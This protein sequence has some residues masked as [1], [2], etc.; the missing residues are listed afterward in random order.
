M[1]GS[2]RLVCLAFCP[3]VAACPEIQPADLDGSPGSRDATARDGSAPD[4]SRAD[5]LE[6]ECSPAPSGLVAWWRLD[7]SAGDAVGSYDGSVLGG[8]GFAAARVDQGLVLDGV[9]DAVLVEFDEELYPAGSFSLEVWVATTQA[10]GALID[11]Y[12]YGGSSCSPGCRAVFLLRL[13]GGAPEFVMRSTDGGDEETQSLLGTV[14]VDDGDY[15]HVV[16]IRSEEDAELRIYVDGAPAGSTTLEAKA[17]GALDPGP[18]G[19]LDPLVIG[20]RRLTGGSLDLDDFVRGRLDEVGY[21]DRALGVS[22]V[23]AIHA[24]GSAGKCR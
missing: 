21:Y 14:R 23:A 2:H 1:R 11:H 5:A 7:G 17:S 18:D 22:E 9:N 8:A 12:E 3:L 19:D 24:A 20:A 13:A 15:H 4:G 10:T 16:G 6:A